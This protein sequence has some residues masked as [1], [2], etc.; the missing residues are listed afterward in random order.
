MLT[1]SV[2]LSIT[3]LIAFVIMTY[4]ANTASK[5]VYKQNVIITTVET[6]VNLLAENTNTLRKD[7]ISLKDRHQVASENREKAFEDRM[8]ERDRDFKELMS[9]ISRQEVRINELEI[10]VMRLNTRLEV[11]D[12]LLRATDVVHQHRTSLNR[13]K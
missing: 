4:K 12:T 2:S 9:H 13:I 5:R 11:S 3:V 6:R 1:I 10:Q 7:I 8:K